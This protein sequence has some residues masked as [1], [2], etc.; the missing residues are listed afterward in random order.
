MNHHNELIVF[1]FALSV[2]CIG[3]MGVK[4]F[5]GEVAHNRKMAKKFAEWRKNNP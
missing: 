5:L 2:L 1:C 4:I 3:A